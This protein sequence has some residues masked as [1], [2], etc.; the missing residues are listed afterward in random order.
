MGVTALAAIAIAREGS[1]TVVFLYG[2]LSNASAA[3]SARWPWPAWAAGAGLADLLCCNGRACAVVAAVFRVTEIL[4]FCCWA[5]R[6][7]C[8]AWKN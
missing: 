8:L 3:D 7:F 5:L 6:C 2:S 1:E 4:L